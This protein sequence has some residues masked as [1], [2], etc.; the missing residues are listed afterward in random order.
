MDGEDDL[1]V[2]ESLFV[3]DKNWR[4][5]CLVNGEPQPFYHWYFNN[6]NAL[7]VF[8]ELKTSVGLL[9]GSNLEFPEFMAISGKKYSGE[10]KCLA[11]NRVG[12]VSRQFHVTVKGIQ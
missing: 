4:L 1:L 8:P 2:Q 11:T 12:N 9:R 5:T 7:E 6:I 3:G 10:Y